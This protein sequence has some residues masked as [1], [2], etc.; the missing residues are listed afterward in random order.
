MRLHFSIFGHHFT[1]FLEENYGMFYLPL[2]VFIAQRLVG[3]NKSMKQMIQ[4]K[5]Q[6][7]QLVG[8]KVG[9]RT[10]TQDIQVLS[11]EP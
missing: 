1:T 7:F 2:A 8:G 10:Q 9:P 3:Q 4:M 5:Q 6:K 11:P